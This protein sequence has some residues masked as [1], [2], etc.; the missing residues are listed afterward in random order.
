MISTIA[1]A[2]IF[3]VVAVLVNRLRRQ[4]RA[5]AS[6]ALLWGAMSLPIALLAGFY[7]GMKL[8]LF[9]LTPINFSVLLIVFVYCVIQCM[10]ID[11]D[12]KQV[13]LSERP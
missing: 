3:V 13:R 7:A 5:R 11:K 8:E 6:K 4:G 9:Y 1:L 10:R 12:L 2:G